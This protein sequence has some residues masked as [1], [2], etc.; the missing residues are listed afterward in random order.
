MEASNF[1]AGG[2]AVPTTQVEIAVAC[3]SVNFLLS[4]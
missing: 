3:R 4:C 1:K 2:A